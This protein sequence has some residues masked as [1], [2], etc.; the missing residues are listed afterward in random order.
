M[1][2]ELFLKQEKYFK[3]NSIEKLYNYGSFITCNNLNNSSLE[4]TFSY[5][6][7]KSFSIQPRTNLI[8]AYPTSSFTVKYENCEVSDVTLKLC[9]SG[10]KLTLDLNKLFVSDLEFSFLQKLKLVALKNSIF[11]SNNQKAKKSSKPFIST[12]K[13]I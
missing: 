3:P 8:L 13:I 5:D 11:S 2:L 6:F 9:P 7:K 10:N 1:S 4:L 12:I